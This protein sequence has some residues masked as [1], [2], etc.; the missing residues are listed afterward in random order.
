MVKRIISFLGK[1]INGLHEAAYLLGLFAILSQVL[2]LVRDRLL[3]HTFGAGTTLDLYYAAFRIPD[4]I[5]VIVASFFSA[6][7]VIPHLSAKIREGVAPGKH[8]LSVLFSAFL[9]LMT[10]ASMLAFVLVPYIIPY[11]FPGFA[12]EPLRSEI[13]LMTRILLLS[14]IFLGLSNLFA[15]VT[16]LY[17]RFF[18]YGISP[19]LYNIGIIVGVVFLTPRFGVSGLVW[20]VALGAVMHFLVQAPFVIRKGL[21]PRLIISL[22]RFREINGLVLVAL[23]RTLALSAQELTR[24][25]LV[26][27]ASLMNVGSISIF[28]LS[29][30]LQSVPLSIIGVSYS[31]AAFPT[32][33]N[34]FAS[35]EKGKFVDLV[36]TTS[37]YIIFFSLPLIALFVVLRAHIVRV[38]LGSGEFGWQDTRLTAAALAMF[39]IS[40]AAQGLILIFTRAR[41]A[42]GDTRTSFYINIASVIVTITSAFGLAYLVKVMP[43]FQEIFDTL[44]RV[45]DIYGTAVL[46]LP[47]SFSIGSIFGATLHIFTFDR[48]MEPKGIARSLVSV[49]LRMS[50]VA[51]CIGVVSY[52][53]LNI[54]DQLFNSYMPLDTLAGIFTHGLVAGVVGVVAGIM[55]LVIM[56]SKELTE[57]TIAIRRKFWDTPVIGPDPTV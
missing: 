48:D 55:L 11:L 2:A 45:G 43:A 22:K 39:V 15:S 41:Y 16:Q 19:L 51:I 40:L 18:I 7:I 14:P 23:P 53:T 52:I 27:L 13:I 35:G 12:A 32:L 20:G 33:A 37:R 17:N 9:V 36:T 47:L 4:F 5:F 26:F 30:N 21:L 56:G 46:M 3:V 29:Y 44:L 24:F 1:E 57:V 6:S 54:T 10:S 49:T 28:S 34:L 42:S 50:V 8:F 25:F 38:I 31:L